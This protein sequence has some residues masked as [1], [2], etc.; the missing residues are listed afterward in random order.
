MDQDEANALF[1]RVMLRR[2]AMASESA[3]R[4]GG[5]EG[6]SLRETRAAQHATTVRS[7]PCSRTKTDA[8][9]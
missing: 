3:G 7:G 1:I 9:Y 2:T 5:I 8:I 4:E 6:S